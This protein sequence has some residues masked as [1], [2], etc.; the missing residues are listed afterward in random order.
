MYEMKIGEATWKADWHVTLCRFFCLGALHY[1]L[2]NDIENALKCM[3][4][5][6]L[7]TDDFKYD[8]RAYISC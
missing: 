6:L 8:V 2:T 7:H 3:K 4:Y 5:L 1:G